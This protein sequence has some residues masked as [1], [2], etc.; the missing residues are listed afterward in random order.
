MQQP[1]PFQMNHFMFNILEFKNHMHKV[2]ELQMPWLLL[3][4]SYPAQST[5]QYKMS[6]NENK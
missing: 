2:W 5:L 6:S 3:Q 4:M 1:D